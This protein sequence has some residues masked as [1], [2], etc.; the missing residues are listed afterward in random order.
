MH[1]EATNNV[2]KTDNA[3]PLASGII[4]LALLSASLRAQATGA[5]ISGT[6]TDPSGAAVP[7]AK[8]SVKNIATGESREIQTNTGGMYSVSNL[9][10]GDYE[11][12]VSAE[13][14]GNRVSQLTLSAG[15]TRTMDLALSASSNTATPPSLGD[16]GFPVDPSQG[17]AQDQ[18]RLNRRSHLLKMHQR[19]G[20]ITLAPLI[21]TIATSN[22][23]AGKRS[24]ATGR[25]IHGG[26]GAVTADMYFMTA[27]YALR[28]PRIPGT[29]TRGPIRLHKALAWIHGPG[30]ILTPIGSHG[31]QSREPRG[32]G[33]RDRPDSFRC[34]HRY[35]CRIWSCRRVRINQILK[36]NS[37][38]I[39]KQNS[40]QI[41][42]QLSNWAYE[43]KNTDGDPAVT[44]S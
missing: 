15:A 9:A 30:M 43:N 16:L 12:S 2:T 14:L 7:N 35:L 1:Q 31:L 28:A 6:I 20:L 10:P 19:F 4:L 13:G 22:L 44:V 34:G 38:Q 21:A 36:Q 23:A 41:L 8:V 11:V 39:L 26:F 18:A 27:Y 32:K 17:N 37:N 25:D 5:T 40:N 24:T 33:S 29:T 3:L 42:E